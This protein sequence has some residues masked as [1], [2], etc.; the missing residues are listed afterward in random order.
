MVNLRIKAN[1]DQI[2]KSIEENKA[3]STSKEEEQMGYQ[4]LYRTVVENLVSDMAMLKLP[5]IQIT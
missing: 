3:T 1:K 2:A 5:V 4:L